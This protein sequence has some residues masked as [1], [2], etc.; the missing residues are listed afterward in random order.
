MGITGQGS[1]VVRRHVGV[2][3][4]S[5]LPI[6]RMAG[7]AF[8]AG[9]ALVLRPKRV[10]RGSRRRTFVMGSSPRTSLRSGGENAAKGRE[11]RKELRQMKRELI[12]GGLLDKRWRDSFLS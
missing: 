3:R 8:M 2:P 7:A 1:D 9:P 12:A 5:V 11:I 6:R 10:E 4:V